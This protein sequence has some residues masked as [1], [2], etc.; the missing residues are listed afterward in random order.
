MADDVQLRLAGVDDAPAMLDVIQR[1][2]AARPAVDPPPAALSDTVDDVRRQLE[3]GHGV[4]AEIDGVVSGCLL[5]SGPEDDLPADGRHARV[6]GV[7]RVSVLPEARN[8]GLASALVHGAADVALDLGATHLEL[9]SRR[10]FPQTMAWWIHHGFVRH[11]EVELGW[12]LRAALPTRV[13]V[14]DAAA[15]QRLGAWLATL[16]RAGDVLVLDGELGAGKTT[17]T[18]GLGAGLAVDGPIISPTFVLSRIHPARV[19]GAPGLVHVDAYRLASAA[20]VEDLDLEDSLADHVT[21]VEWGRGVAETL[22]D[23]RLEIEIRR[24]LADESADGEADGRDVLLMGVGERWRGVSLTP[25][26]G[27]APDEPVAPDE[28]IERSA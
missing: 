23:D 18:Q 28:R 7:H 25:P 4:V 2:F 9:L 13:H 20:E 12:M 24:P 10:E 8:N 3:S 6:V 27:L 16:V 11:A 22:S 19:E 21:V 26:S 14:P 5:L 15:M 1:A 17:L